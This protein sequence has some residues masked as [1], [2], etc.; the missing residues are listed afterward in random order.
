MS[1]SFISPTVH[2]YSRWW[3]KIV[4]VFGLIIILPFIYYIA[5]TIKY[6]WQIKQGE[7]VVIDDWH[8]NFSSNG[9]SEVVRQ[10][11]QAQVASHSISYFGNA[12]APITIVE[13]VDFKCPNCLLAAPALSQLVTTYGKKVRVLVRQFPLSVHP[14]ADELSAVAV[15]AANQGRFP[16]MYDALFANASS[17]SVPLGDSDWQLLAAAANVDEAK[18]RTCAKSDAVTKTISDDYVAGAGF[19]VGGTPTFFING[20]KV[21][22]AVPY[23]AWQ[24]YLSRLG[25]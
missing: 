12:N 2:W 14:G 6:V 9:S 25:Y 7:P 3:G 13:F 16:A 18:L 17:L 21:E 10:V 23:T 4:I 22:G 20:T 1:G 19:G 24:K 5:T 15:C 11:D 8:N